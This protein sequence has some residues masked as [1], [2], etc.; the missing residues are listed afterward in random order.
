MICQ[1]CNAFCRS[2][3]LAWADLDK[4]DMCNQT[5]LVTVE[6]HDV[7]HTRWVINMPVVQDRDASTTPSASAFATSS[8][9][10]D[11][12]TGEVL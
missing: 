2:F 5:N 8:T 7:L 9:S 1:C 10:T 3:I 12:P 11:F 6:K 4:Q